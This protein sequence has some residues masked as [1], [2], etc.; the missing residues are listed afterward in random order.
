MAFTLLFWPKKEEGIKEWTRSVFWER[1]EK[2]GFRHTQ[3]T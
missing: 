1:W 2:E 3:I